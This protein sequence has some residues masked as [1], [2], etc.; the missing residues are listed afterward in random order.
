MKNWDGVL[1]ALYLFLAVLLG[2]FA[3]HGLEGKLEPRSLEIFKT[4]A[5]YQTTHGLGLLF[6]YLI[7]QH[8]QNKWLKIAALFLAVGVVL[9]SGSLYALAMLPEMRMLGMITPFGGLS[10]LIG[11][12]ILAFA[13]FRQK[14]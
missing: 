2:A 1:G 10:F 6:I 12:A 13:I 8:L 11:W 5:T 3:A 4:A 14:S 7:R 9:F